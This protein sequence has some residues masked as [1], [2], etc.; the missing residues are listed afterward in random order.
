[1]ETELGGHQ[2]SAASILSLP[3]PAR[4][5][6]P[7]GFA[8]RLVH[9][10]QN[11]H[12]RQLVCVTRCNSGTHQYLLFLEP[13]RV[14]SFFFEDREKSNERYAPTRECGGARQGPLGARGRKP[15]TDGRRESL[16]CGE[17]EGEERRRMLNTRQS[18]GFRCAMSRNVPLKRCGSGSFDGYRAQRRGLM[19]IGGPYLVP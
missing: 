14:L 6:S 19:P 16:R 8:E 2:F 10:T 15:T 13:C 1:M 18:Y 12:H 3:T 9:K 7:T 17:K 11:G 4:H 5:S